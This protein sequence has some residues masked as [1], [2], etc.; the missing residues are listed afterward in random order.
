MAVMTTAASDRS[1]ASRVRS[2][3]TAARIGIAN[4]S[5]A[6]WDDSRLVRNVEAASP[7]T[8]CSPP[9]PLLAI[10]DAGETR[11]GDWKGKR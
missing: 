11:S 10:T 4:A 3:R 2:S 8:P 9:Y 5:S 1:P 7:T 6:P